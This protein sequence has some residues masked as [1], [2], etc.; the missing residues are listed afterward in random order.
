M[1]S[2]T[3]CTLL[4]RR[5]SG[6]SGTFGC[7]VADNTCVVCQ[8]RERD[9]GQTCEPCRRW[10]PVA[11]A[12]IPDLADRLHDQL[13][14]DD[15]SNAAPVLV[16]LTCGLTAPAGT[17][18]HHPGRPEYDYSPTGKWHGGWTPR[19]IIRRA[20]GPAPSIAP[21]IIISGG[22][23]EAPVPID[24]H[25]HDLLGDVIRDGGRPIDITGDNWIPAS[26]LTPVAVNHTR[27]K[28]TERRE[29][30]DD[31]TVTLHR[32]FRHV[33][34]RLTVMDRQS[35]R[36]ANGRPVMIPAG[37]L[38]ASSPSRRSSTRRCGRGLMPAHPVPATGPPPPSPAWSTGWVSASTGR[39]TTTRASTRS[40]PPS[41]R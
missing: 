32:D 12:S 28:V 1:K 8:K 7:R 34:E 27:F 37:D 24:V 6:P 5:T 40:P 22:D 4:N 2:S 9:T 16:C 31:G 25:I 19:R 26:S 33:R 20:A 41:G 29:E 35:R 39:A 11:L 15:D 30:H 10:L 23:G 21:D 3:D 18:P 17:T 13:I 38:A 36:D 14:P